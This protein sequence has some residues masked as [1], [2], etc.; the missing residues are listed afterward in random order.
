MAGLA[1][2]V[3]DFHVFGDGD[4]IDL[5]D[6]PFFLGELLGCTRRI[7]RKTVI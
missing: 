2:N 6:N 3:E 1:L 7:T 4:V 5:M